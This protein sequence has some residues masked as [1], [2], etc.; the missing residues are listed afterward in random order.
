MKSL[1]LLGFFIASN[2]AIEASASDALVKCTSP[3][4]KIT[5]QQGSCPNDTKIE[6]M[7]NITQNSGSITSEAWRFTRN[8]DSMTGAVTCT[9]RSPEILVGTKREYIY[10]QLVVV[11]TTSE[12]LVMLTSG[13][14]AAIF[15]HKIHG[16]GIKVG[17]SALLPFASRPTQS[18]LIM[19][20][21]TGG[22]IVES[23]HQY[24]TARVRVRIWPW[25]ETYDSVSVSMQG[26]KQAFALAKQCAEQL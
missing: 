4:G 5:Y 11:A 8:T 2:A 10:L 12:P 25:D 20:T 24:P 14:S 23:M 17:E 26:F 22:P 7:K 15:H 18:T 21:G 6:V 13:K 16:T 1:V 3:S 19:P 9:A